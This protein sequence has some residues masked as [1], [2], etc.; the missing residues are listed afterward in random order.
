MSERTIRARGIILNDK[1]KLIEVDGHTYLL[2]DFEH[3]SDETVL[4]V[5][6]TIRVPKGGNVVIHD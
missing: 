6:T 5:V 2:R 3:W 4:H 1:G